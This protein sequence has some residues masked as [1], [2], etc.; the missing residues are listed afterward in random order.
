MCGGQSPIA[1]QTGN[2]ARNKYKSSRNL[3]IVSAYDKG[4]AEKLKQ[5]SRIENP[6][7]RMKAYASSGI[8]SIQSIEGQKAAV[9][10]VLHKE[11]VINQRLIIREEMGENIK[12]FHSQYYS[13][14]IIL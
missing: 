10:F 1:A 3:G 7:E 5:A 11:A 8:T 12:S 9:A 6:D 2:I 4:I 14:G 13:Y